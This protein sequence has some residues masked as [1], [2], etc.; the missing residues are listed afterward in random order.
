MAST[1]ILGL[2]IGSQQIKAA[3]VRRRRQQVTLGGAARVPTPPN[4]VQDGAILDTDQ[5][6]SAVRSMVQAHGLANM[7]TVAAVSGS[8]VL[9]RAIKMPDM[10][11]ATLRKSMRFEAAKHLDAGKNA[12]GIDA[13]AVEFEVMGRSGNPPQLDVLLVVAPNALVQTRQ[14]AMENA[15]LEPLAVDVEAFAL[16]R[17]VEAAARSP[18]PEEALVVLD[19]GASYT[20]LNIVMNGDVAVTRSIPVG[21]SALTASIASLLN[22]SPEEAEK[23]KREIALPAEGEQPEEPTARRLLEV[24]IPFVDEIVR[25]LRRSVIYF[26]SQAAE[27][28]LQVAVDQ[29]ILSGGSTQL[30]GLHAY[31]SARLGMEVTTLDLSGIPSNAGPL[32]LLEN[33]GAEFTVALG[34]A[35]KEV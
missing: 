33:H 2:D 4:T 9:V 17:A 29:L 19:V 10:P 8:H 23:L 12:F 27:A 22:V 5:V 24:T 34:L 14:K 35:L 25:E 13:S 6:T 3:W 15:G 21:G 7:E 11:T 18:R 28:G 26:Q 20:D 31:L 30:R 32:P 1:G 16:L